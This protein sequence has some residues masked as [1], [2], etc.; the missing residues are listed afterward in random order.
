MSFACSTSSIFGTGLQSKIVRTQSR[1][2]ETADEVAYTCTA[3]GL[4]LPEVGRACLPLSV[5]RLCVLLDKVVGHSIAP[6]RVRRAA[7]SFLL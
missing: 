6:A 2:G 4:C 5:A 3:H 1:Q 7:P